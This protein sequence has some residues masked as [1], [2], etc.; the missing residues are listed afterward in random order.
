MVARCDD[1]RAGKWSPDAAT[2][3]VLSERTMRPTQ[4]QKC[5]LFI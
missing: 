2:R 1:P 3:L 5:L 4:R